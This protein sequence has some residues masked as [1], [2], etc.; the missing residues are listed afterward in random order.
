MG[1]LFSLLGHRGGPLHLENWQSPNRGGR[2][3]ISNNIRADVSVF[4]SLLGAG[5]AGLSRANTSASGSGR[6]TRLVL[7]CLEA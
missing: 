3:N 6:V 7:R 1:T 4:G 2:I 5:C